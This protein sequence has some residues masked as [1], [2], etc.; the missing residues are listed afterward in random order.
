MLSCLIKVNVDQLKKRAERFGVNVSSISQRVTFSPNTH[1]CSQCNITYYSFY[2][3]PFLNNPPIRMD[4]TFN[5][6][7]LFFFAAWGGWKAEEEEGEVWSHNKY[8]ISWFGWCWGVFSLQRLFIFL[9]DNICQLYCYISLQ[10]SKLRLKTPW[11]KKI[12][13]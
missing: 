3:I 9:I 6:S 13:C 2:N 12:V 7:V 4:S 8:R 10:H 5:I 1:W 11:G